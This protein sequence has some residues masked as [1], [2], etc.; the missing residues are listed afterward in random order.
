MVDLRFI[1]GRASVSTAKAMRKGRGRMFRVII[2]VSPTLV[3]LPLT[4]SELWGN[5][6]MSDSD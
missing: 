2:S 5:R 3:T 1:I 6:D 4:W